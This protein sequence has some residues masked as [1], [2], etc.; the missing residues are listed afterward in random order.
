MN[1]SATQIEELIDMFKELSIED[2]CDNN[3]EHSVRSIKSPRISSGQRS[4]AQSLMSQG[5]RRSYKCQLCGGCFRKTSDLIRHMKGPH[6]QA[7]S[8]VFRCRDG[9][10]YT[11]RKD[12]YKRHLVVCRKKAM[13][14]RPFHCRCGQADLAEKHHIA[15]IRTCRHGRSRPP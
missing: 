9:H 6:R 10:Y 4:S 12:N 5:T 15:H 1:A 11:A 2:P 13:S 8:A 3:S 7:G 14:G